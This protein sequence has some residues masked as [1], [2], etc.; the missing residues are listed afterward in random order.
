MQVAWPASLATTQVE[1]SCRLPVLDVS[2]AGA[3]I[4]DA[5]I[6]FPAGTL[7]PAGTGG[8][9]YDWVVSRWLPVGH[10]SVSPDGRRYAIAKDWSPGP[11]SPSQIHVVDAATGADMVVATMPDQREYGVVDFT[12]SGV[13]VVPI[14]DPPEAGVWRLDPNSG[15]LTKTSDGYYQPPAGEWI[16]VVDPRDPNH[17]FSHATG[18]PIAQP[19]RIDRRDDSGTARMWIYKPGYWLYWF[20]F[21]GSPL[22]LVQA[23]RVNT[24]TGREDYEFLLV[25]SPGRFT[26]LAGYSGSEPSPYHD[27]VFATG[28]ADDHGVWISGIGSLYLIRTSGAI[29]RVSD[30]AGV[31]VNSCR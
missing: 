11:P 25:T 23:S 31:P 21:T 8:W 19:D 9:Y 24:A 1:F 20:A 4:N 14:G 29:S 13:T 22:L 15:A 17:Q 2:S 27:L 18:S 6:D 16:G 3:G 7:T 5:F 30:H 10:Y 12:A 28:L 26:R